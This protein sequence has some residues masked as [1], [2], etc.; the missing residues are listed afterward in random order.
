MRNSRHAKSICYGG[1]KSR[2]SNLLAFS[3]HYLGF[4]RKRNPQGPT[5]AMQNQSLSLEGRNSEIL[6]LLKELPL[7][8]ATRCRVLET[9]HKPRAENSSRYTGVSQGPIVYWT[10]HALRV[11]ENAALDVALR[12]AHATN[13]P[14]LVYQGLSQTYRY[15]SDRHHLFQLQAARD[16]VR[17][18]EKLGIRYAVHVESG[19]NP[20]PGLLQLARTT[21]IVI[22]D[23]FPGEPTERW[24]MRLAALRHL[25][26][27][28]VDTAC[29]V[30]MRL[31]GRAYDRAFA[32][33]DAT[34]KLFAERIPLEWPIVGETS[35]FFEGPMPFAETEI[36]KTD[37]GE[38]VALCNID[39]GVPP[40]ADTMGGSVAGYERWARFQQ[41]SLHRYAQGRNDPCDDAS[42]RMSAY[43]HYGMVSPMRLAREAAR[44]NAEKYLEELLVWRELA[45]NY[46]F[47]RDDYASLKTLP[48]WAIETLES[49]R[50]DPRP[51]IH[52]WETL[53]RAKTEDRLWNACQLSLL[54]HGELHNN[55]RMTWGKAILK[56]TRNASDALALLIDLNHRYALDGRDPASYGGILWCLGQFD[57]PFEPEKP[58]YGVV[59]DRPTEEH[60]RRIKIQSYEAVVNRPISNSPAKVA[61]VGAGIAGAFCART[62]ADQGIE[63]EL[64]DKSRGPSGR[65]ATKRVAIEGTDTS[66]GIT[67]G[68]DHGPPYMTLRDSKWDPWLKSWQDDGLIAPWRGTFVEIDAQGIRPASNEGIRWVG[69]P[70]MSRIGKK[71]AE[72]LSVYYEAPIATAIQ[73]NGRWLLE[74]EPKAPVKSGSFSA[75]VA[76]SNSSRSNRR[77]PFDVVLWST[78]PE[79]LLSLA[80][81]T[82]SW[83]RD[84]SS[85]AMT[86]CW[87]LML[88]LDRRW[89]L[90]FDGARFFQADISW[91]G[92]E[93]SKPKSSSDKDCWVIHAS[94]EWSRSNLELDPDVV[95]QRLLERV[96]RSQSIAMPPVVQAVAHRWRYAYPHWLRDRL[97]TGQPTPSMR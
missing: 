1:G 9:D 19:S 52:S 36:S 87:A 95:S 3:F 8:L 25:T 39:H 77:G 16:L 34:K 82:C 85:H 12:V 35:S 84:L 80:P 58:I 40:V 68:L 7:H 76:S 62:L 30:P 27:V 32:F 41:T 23:D 28:A 71:L 91:M 2:F 67:L 18:Y 86:P 22:T 51:A 56:W 31:V 69:I 89:E 75:S 24:A 6:G 26:V 92:R 15:A 57:R 60:L 70:G 63:V 55:V 14:I 53:A 64:F 21:D 94:P 44:V 88:V 90:P 47:Y 46:C 13:R 5:K 17:G 81:A 59:R 97:I 33:R 61:V 54:R 37:L 48:R 11:D 93:S 78:P 49:H 43:L 4:D 96:Q 29:V 72:G 65:C 79:Q 73:E 66:E 74:S 10:H 83:Y 42:S 45:Y 38:L 50:S 20:Q